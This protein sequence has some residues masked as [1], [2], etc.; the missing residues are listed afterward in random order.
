MANKD[1]A[2]KVVADNDLG[3][4]DIFWK[5]GEP[6]PDWV[7]EP[8]LHASPVVAQAFLDASKEHSKRREAIL[9]MLDLGEELDQAPLPGEPGEQLLLI[10]IPIRRYKKTFV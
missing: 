5:E 6:H 2:A 7:N 10:D 8:L 9:S 4:P 1:A 3:V